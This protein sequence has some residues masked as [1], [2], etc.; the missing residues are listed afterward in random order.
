MYSPP[1]KYG[2]FLQNSRRK[3]TRFNFIKRTVESIVPH[4]EINGLLIYE[5]ASPT[6]PTAK[7]AIRNS[8][9]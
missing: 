6:W 1:I 9:Y 5:M 4:V 7:N 3:Q 8:R 2:D